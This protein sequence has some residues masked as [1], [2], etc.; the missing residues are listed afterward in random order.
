[1]CRSNAKTLLF[2][3]DTL[4]RDILQDTSAL[5]AVNFDWHRQLQFLGR[6]L[7]E[8]PMIIILIFEPPPILL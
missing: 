8:D 5:V 4:D 3:G 1:M 6:Q 7:L 2:T